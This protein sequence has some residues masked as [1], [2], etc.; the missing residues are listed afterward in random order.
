MTM[1]AID[2][3]E[4]PPPKKYAESSIDTGSGRRPCRACKKHHGSENAHIKCL[5]NALDAAD[6]K[7][8]NRTRRH[9]EELAR[10]RAEIR[11]EKLIEANPGGTIVIPDSEEKKK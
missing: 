9:E 6:E 5:E 8:K 2:D 4:P 3:P 11:G 10:V 7:W 1:A